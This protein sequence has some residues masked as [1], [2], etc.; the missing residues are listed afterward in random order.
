[1]TGFRL[2][3]PLLVVWLLMLALAAPAMAQDAE[4]TA[5]DRDFVTR[6]LEDNLSGA[7]RHVVL[8]GFQGALSSRATFQ[9]L[10]IADDKGV[11]L[12]IN[13]GSIQWNRR[14]LL[15]RR[16]DIAE[17]SAEEIVVARRPVAEEGRTAEAGDFALPTLP[18]SVMVQHISAQRVVLD[19]S[20]LGE[21]AVVSLDGAMVL[22]GGAGE[23]R[24]AVQRTDDKQGTFGLNVGFSNATRVLRTDLLL[25]EGPGGI[26]AHLI[27]LEGKPA[28]RA[29]IRG[30]GPL[31]DFTADLS[32]A[33]DGQPRVTGQVALTGETGEDG[34]AQGFR[35]RLGGDVAALLPADRRAFFGDQA[36]VLVQ[37]TRTPDGALSVPVLLVDT[38]ALNVSGGFALDAAGAPRSASL[39]MTLGEAANAPDLPTRLPFGKAE[40]TVQTGRLMLSY[41]RAS[42]AGWT[43]TGA[44]GQVTNPDVALAA[45]SLDGAGQV[46]RTDAG[47]QGIDGRLALGAEGLAPS[48]AGLAEALGEA[49]TLETGFDWTR[50]RALLLRDLVLAGADYRLSGEATLD[51]LTSGLT[52]TADLRAEYQD[53]ARLSTLAGRP[54][55]GAVSAEVTGHGTLLTGA[56]GV[57][58]RVVGQ[59]IT[60]DQPQLDRL[61]AGTTAITL[62]AQ[63]DSGGIEISELTLD[64][65]R[66]TV[67]GEGR[68]SSEDADLRAA[69]ELASLTTVDADFDGALT[70]QAAITGPAGARRLVLDGQALD[71]QTGISHLDAVLGG[72]T[73][74]QVDLRQTGGGFVIKVLDLANAQLTLRAQGNLTPG[75]MD[76]HIDLTVPD[77]TAIDPEWG[78]A[79]SLGGTVAEGADGR[80]FALTGTGEALAIGDVRADGLLKGTTKLELRGTQDGQVITLDVAR[81]ANGQVSLDASGVYGPGQTDLQGRVALPSLRVMGP[82][83]A[84][85]VAL[86]G[87]VTAA[88]GGGHDITVDGTVRDLSIAQNGNAAALTGETRVTLRAQEQGCTVRFQQAEVSNPRLRAEASGRVGGGD[89]DLAIRAD[90]DSLAFLGRN[91]RGAVSVNARLLDDGSQQTLTATGE[92]RGLAVGNPQ[93]DPLLAGSTRL[94]VD[95]T[96]RGPQI[97]VRRLD[98]ANNQL[99]VTASGDLDSAI[100]VDARLNDLGLLV[101]EFPGPAAA[102]GT[103]TRAG[104]RIRVDIRGT[105]PGA[106]QVQVAGTV[107]QDFSTVNLTVMGSAESA[108]ANPFLRVRSVQGP[109]SFDLAINGRPGME[110]MT[111]RIGMANGSFV[112]PRLGIRVDGLRMDARLDRGR[113]ALDGSGEVAAG[114]RVTVSG[115]ITL[116]GG[117]SVDLVADMV[118]VV[119]RD[120]NLYSTRINGR[121]TVTGL[122]ADGP[123]VAGTLRL[124]DTEL[125]IPSTGLGGAR[126]I[127]EIVHLNDRPPVRATRAKAGLLP[128]PGEDSTAAGMAGP[129]ATPPA[130]PARLDLTI[131]A[132]SQVFIRG[133]GVDAEMG[134]RVRLTGRA[135]NI[136]PIG[137]F[138]LIR[139]RVDLLGKRFDLTEGI[140]EL[141]GSL[142]P[143]I[144]LVAQTHQDGITT[145]IIIDGDL[146]DPEITFAS[147]PDMPQEEV[148]SQLLFGRGLDRITPMQ[149]VQLANAVAVLAG[150]GGEGIVGR[151]RESVG[152]DDLD[153]QTDD[154]GNVTLRAGRYLSENVYTDVVVGSDGTSTIEINLDLSPAVTARGSVA[155]DGTS[156]IGLFYERDY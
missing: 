92:A 118:D 49:V 90:V 127:P 141:Q 48:E 130:V 39:L 54:L 53:L 97:T 88:A 12:T 51:G 75:A 6:F 20:L 137:M 119:M 83:Y 45:L 78:G 43:L 108:M 71:L 68:I 67:Q 136:I 144:R 9:R 28:V 22:S 105:G 116:N 57:E 60:A 44:L 99:R 74:L 138:E 11:W 73:E 143:V 107:A 19:P 121:V 109:I 31:D 104:D 154:N 152:L 82:G 155:S 120:P 145:R 150:R 103:L 42:G 29:V 98:V 131:E 2:F 133:R 58:A 3:R 61:L 10:T 26:V 95:V 14:A 89:T 13:G 24:F 110:A 7:G 52:L 153:L 32:L 115:A 41:D 117:R 36:Q 56:F 4:E 65:Q 123:L 100:R 76:A 124:S 129:A 85:A 125:R 77:L 87:R 102:D 84:G 126:D 86:D 111:G 81:L 8:E 79:L 94:D 142:V 21:E 122:L 16:V 33:T 38:A 70:M 147:D 148:L 34:T 135:N 96:R 17:L 134:G 66:L 40:T 140:L 30:E 46:R 35:L 156:A 18:V 27:G 72:Q 15:L 64:G 5:A 101:R 63:R 113:I 146:R 37:G 50:G 69:L 114:G 93:L 91:L 59:D 132:P 149:A 1:M 139:G 112:D 55:T 62:A 151:L 106:A 80:N 25:D 23:V 128:W 47:L